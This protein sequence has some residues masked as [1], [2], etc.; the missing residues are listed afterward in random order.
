MP[1]IW[2]RHYIHLFRFLSVSVSKLLAVAIAV[3][4]TASLFAHPNADS[5]D[6]YFSGLL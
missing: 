4:L 2:R 5:T 6:V 3:F 1:A